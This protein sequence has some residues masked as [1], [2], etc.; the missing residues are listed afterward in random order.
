MGAGRNS[1]LTIYL[2]VVAVV[3]LIAFRWGTP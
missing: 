3:T 1:I 2:A